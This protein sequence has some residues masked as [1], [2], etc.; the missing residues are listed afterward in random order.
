MQGLHTAGD[1]RVA[2]TAFNLPTN[3]G[4]RQRQ[5]VGQHAAMRR[6]LKYLDNLLIAQYQA[7]TRQTQV[8]IPVVTC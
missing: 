5:Q 1:T 3:F 4:T 8:Q 2:S 6:L 7:V